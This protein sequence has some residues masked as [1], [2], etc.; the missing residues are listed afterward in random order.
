[1][2][3]PHGATPPHIQKQL[4]F[5]ANRERE[6]EQLMKMGIIYSVGVYQ[7]GGGVSGGRERY[8]NWKHLGPVEG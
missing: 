4:I 1:M 7:W 3:P 6:K 2:L 8:L 5:L